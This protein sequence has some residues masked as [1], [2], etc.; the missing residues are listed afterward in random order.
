VLTLFSPELAA[1]TGINVSR[2]NLYY[3]LI[4]SLTVLLGLRFLGA[5]LVA[6]SSSSQRPLGDS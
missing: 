1:A 3:L 4:F 6:P 5:L 2:L